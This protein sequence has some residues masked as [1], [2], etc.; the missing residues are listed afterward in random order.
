MNLRHF[1]QCIF[2]TAACLS[3]VVAQKPD[4]QDSTKISFDDK[5]LT[6]HYG[7]PAMRGRKI[8]GAFVPY[9]KV[10]R[11]GSGAVTTLTSDVDFEI[12]GAIVPRGT[13][14]L[15]TLPNEEHWKLIINKQVGQWGTMY[16]PSLDLARIDLT[17][18]K[19][20]SPVEYLSIKLEKTNNEGGMFKIEWETTSLSVPFH[21]M[22]ESLLPS[23][24]DSADI[25][26]NAQHISVNY[27]SP[28][29]RG[30]KIMGSVVPYGKVWRTGANAATSFTT[31][32]DLM[33][34]KVLVPRG[35]YTLYSLPSSKQWKLIINKQTG[36]WGTVYNEK[37]DLTRIPLKKR[38]L[39][40]P[41]EK[42]TI[43]MKRINETS[44]EMIL[45]W[46][47]TQ[48]SIPIQV[49]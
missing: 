22:K 6:V 33:I 32:A 21:I 23:P 12:D 16:N 19:L 47:K 3:V 5:K 44:C 34:G 1:H 37:L 28:S 48:L 13:Y 10:W 38:L 36:Q 26:L 49:K 14:S 35:S 31:Q 29:I 15:F 42:F 7:K 39:N 11:T 9:Y 24:R 41:V 18:R 17:K 45:A 40:E 46:E 4:P 25:V 30:R 20:K 8:F 43:S 27:G 2:V